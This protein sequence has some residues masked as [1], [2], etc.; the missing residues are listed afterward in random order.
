MEQCIEHALQNREKRLNNCPDAPVWIQ[1]DIAVLFLDPAPAQ[2]VSP[3]PKQ[4]GPCSYVL[5][6]FVVSD[7][8]M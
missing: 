1:P 5:A 2:T 7:K 6:V 3:N 8:V 4:H